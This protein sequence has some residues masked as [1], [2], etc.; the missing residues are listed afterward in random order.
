MPAAPGT[1]ARRVGAGLVAAGLLTACGATPDEPG[2]GE[3]TGVVVSR[4]DS[5]VIGGDGVSDTYRRLVVLRRDELLEA[6][7]STW[8]GK[9]EPEPHEYANLVV[10]LPVSEL[11]ELGQDHP[12][13]AG[14]AVAEVSEGRFRVAWSDDPRYLCLGNPAT[15]DGIEMVSTAGCVEV[16]EP[17]PAAVTV[18]VHIGGL[19]IEG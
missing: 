1:V 5:V 10:R 12:A 3:L 8:P 16:T 18:V 2:A 15:V 7:A 14:P 9:D 6:Y 4:G 17:P 11:V 19:A 13:T